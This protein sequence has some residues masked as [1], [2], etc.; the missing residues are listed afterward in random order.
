MRNFLA[1]GDAL[2][3]TNTTGAAIASGEGVVLGSIFGVAAGPIP[4][5]AEGV[6]NV[7]G[8]YLLP[9]AGTQ[10]WSVGDVVYW[11]AAEKRATKTA[12]GNTKIGVA[13]KAV[14]GGAGDTQGAVR[15][16]GSF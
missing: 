10:A 1:R 7:T 16:N 6:I 8:V 2:T 14:A 5:N 15:L 4:V 12:A 11:E 3:I 13:T 9:K